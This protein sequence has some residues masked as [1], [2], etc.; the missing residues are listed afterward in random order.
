VG[1]YLSEGIGGDTSR[2]IGQGRK[3]L[4]VPGM[5]SETIFVAIASRP[6]LRTGGERYLSEV[7]RYVAGRGWG[8]VRLIVLSDLPV[9]VRRGGVVLSSFLTN[10]WLLRRLLRIQG[11]PIVLLEDFHHHPRVVIAN[12]VLKL[13]RPVRIVG[14]VQSHL[15]Y[16]SI[17]RSSLARVLDQI[18]VRHFFRQVDVII[19]NSRSTAEGVLQFGIDR[20]KIRVV[21]PGLSPPRRSAQT[22]AIPQLV[23]RGRTNIL[24][25]GRCEPIKGLEDLLKAMALLGDHDVRLGIVGDTDED[26]EYFE[27]LRQLVGRLGLRTRVHFVGRIDE[28]AVL[29]EWYARSDI[30]VLPSLW[31]GYG[32][33]LLEAMSFGLPVIATRVGGIPEIVSDGR[34]GL[35][36][37]AGNVPDLARAMRY[38]IEHP[39]YARTLSDGA[40]ETVSPAREWTKVGE[41]VWGILEEACLCR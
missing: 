17:L 10:L 22:Q 9:W 30:L 8:D 40:L 18:A 27:S 36:V 37:E 41:E 25:V 24:F 2:R 11:R 23:T 19:A 32:I 33:V 3:G 34:N 13:L 15:F 7:Y 29:A 4:M 39:E 38:L 1:D 28:E 26:P 31:E 6:T 12:W 5:V 16:H 21:H 20:S 14:I 35:L